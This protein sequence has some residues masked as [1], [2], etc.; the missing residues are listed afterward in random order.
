MWKEQCN[1]ISEQRIKCWWINGN[2]GQYAKPE[3][4]TKKKGESNEVRKMLNTEK[5]QR[6][7]KIAPFGEWIKR[8][9]II[10]ACSSINLNENISF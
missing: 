4:R 6:E 7:E 1:A 10:C 5:G 9:S 2:T 3:T 8:F